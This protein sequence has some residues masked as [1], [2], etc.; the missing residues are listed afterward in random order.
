MQFHKSLFR[1]YKVSSKSER[2]NKD[3]VTLLKN[4]IWSYTDNV[5]YL[6][7]I[8]DMNIIGDYYA[9]GKPKARDKEFKINSEGFT[10]LGVDWIKCKGP[11]KFSTISKYFSNYKEID[12]GVADLKLALK[13]AKKISKS[14]FDRRIYLKPNKIKI[15]VIPKTINFGDTETVNTI[16][17]PL[18]IRNNPILLNI[19]LFPSLTSLLKLGIHQSKT[20]PL[21]LIYK[22]YKYLIM[23][24]LID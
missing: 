24:L 6:G 12:I 8:P 5:S 2:G 14:K 17:T 23:P 1:A 11:Y 16:E 20:S 22:D 9:T 4:K 13:E 21:V 10:C 15:S 19:D 3:M 7:D 18:D